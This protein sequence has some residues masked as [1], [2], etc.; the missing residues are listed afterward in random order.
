MKQRGVGAVRRVIGG[1]P[2]YAEV[3]LTADVSSS[4]EIVDLCS[5]EGWKGQGHIEDASAD[6]YGDWKRGATT[7][8]ELG[9]HRAGVAARTELVRITG[10][11][12]DT[13]AEI[14][15]CAAMRAIWQA[16]CY[17]PTPDD[18]EL[19]DGKL[20]ASWRPTG[21]GS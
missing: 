5:G 16:V 11:M 12:T 1:L 9:L 2:L 7:G 17:L 4:S 18:L 13:N 8:V 15:A 21:A 3:E 14:V 20:A 10:M 6:G 19:I